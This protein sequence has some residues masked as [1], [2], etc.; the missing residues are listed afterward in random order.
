M[1]KKN[2]EAWCFTFCQSDSENKN[3]YVRIEG[4]YYYARMKMAAEFGT[5][6]AFQYSE[7]EFLPQIKS[8]GLTEL[9]LK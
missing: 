9:V 5:Y 8:F 4:D 2:T 6:W 7:K 1:E 3:K